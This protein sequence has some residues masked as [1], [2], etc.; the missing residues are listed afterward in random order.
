VRVPF[1][2]QWKGKLPAGKVYEH[3][4]IQ[5]DIL[6]TCVAAAGGNVDPAWK[7]DGMDLMPYLTGAKE[8]RPHETLYWRFGKQWGVRHG[9]WKL[10]VGNGGS[11]NPELYDLSRDVSESKDTAAERPE[12]VKELQ[13]L[14]DEWNKQQAPPAWMPPNRAAPAPDGAA[15]QRRRQR[16]N[17]N[18]A[19]P[20]QQPQPGQ[21]RPQQAKP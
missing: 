9:D 3:P 6:P 13:A 19:P 8:G 5:L 15:P 20:A 7:L 10:L 17:R 1:V 18:A 4:V 16:R 11:G 21:A 2:M 12:K 14:Y